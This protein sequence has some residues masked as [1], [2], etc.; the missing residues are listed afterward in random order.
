ML[1]CLL[2]IIHRHTIVYG[3]IYRAFEILLLTVLLLLFVKAEHFYHHLNYPFVQ[4][5]Q[6]SEEHL[7]RDE[8]TVQK[9]CEDRNR[10]VFGC[11]QCKR[12]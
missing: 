6:T 2:R 10:L 8:Q 1:K 9:K 5:M 11:Y 4:R 12:T 3:I 7:V